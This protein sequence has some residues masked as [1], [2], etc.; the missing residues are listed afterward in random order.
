MNSSKVPG[1]Q[2]NSRWRLAQSALASP[3]TIPLRSS[4]R[5]DVKVLVEEHVVTKL[6]GQFFR[7]SRR[8]SNPLASV[9]TICA[10]SVHRPLTYQSTWWGEHRAGP[11]AS[12][13]G[14]S[15]FLEKNGVEPFIGFGLLGERERHRPTEFGRCAYLVTACRRDQPAPLGTSAEIRWVYAPSLRT[16]RGRQLRPLRKLFA[17]HWSS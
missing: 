12:G 17:G 14:R 1:H 8:T 13:L 4:V 6:A 10:R 7:P 5:V 2:T 16:I 15:R 11:P 9:H 3:N